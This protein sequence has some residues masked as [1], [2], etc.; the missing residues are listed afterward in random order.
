M[1]API[2]SIQLTISKLFNVLTTHQSTVLIVSDPGD[3]GKYK[4]SRW[5]HKGRRKEKRRGKDL[6]LE[7]IL[8]KFKILAMEDWSLAIE[9][10]LS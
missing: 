3:A 6:E 8:L 5:S 2:Y 10:L 9:L 1:L 4:N 7:P